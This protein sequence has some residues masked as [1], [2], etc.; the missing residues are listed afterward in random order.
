VFDR[1]GRRVYS[2]NGVGTVTQFVYDANGNV[3]DRI[4]Y[5]NA[6]ATT[7]PAT[8]A[9]LS[10]AVVADPAHDSRLRTVYD[11]LNRPT[12]TIVGTGAVT[13]FI[14]DANGNVVDRT[15]YAN[16]VAPTTAATAA[17]LSA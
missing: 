7:T 8:A 15:G 4:G 13:K 9:A 6:V 17:A 2:V 5:A 16:P 11:A 10:A 12:F 14:Y 3:I 1:D